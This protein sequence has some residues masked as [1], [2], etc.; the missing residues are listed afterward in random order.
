MRIML[1]PTEMPPAGSK[2]YPTVSISIPD[3]DLTMDDLCEMMRSL[4]L[5]AGYSEKTVNEYFGEG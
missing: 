1:I 3:D 5:A 2:E 4:A